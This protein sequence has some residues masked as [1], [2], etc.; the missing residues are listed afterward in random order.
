M[1]KPLFTL[2]LVAVLLLIAPTVSALSLDQAAI[3]ANYGGSW[4]AWKQ[5][6]TLYGSGQN[7]YGIDY[8]YT[9]LFPT[10]AAYQPS[11]ALAFQQFI[12]SQI[13]TFM[14]DVTGISVSPGPLSLDIDFLIF[15]HNTRI[16]SVVFYTSTYMGGAHPNN[17]A[18][19]LTFDQT[20]GQ[21]MQLEDFFLPA[22]DPL[23]VIEPIVV[24]DLQAQ[25]GNDS[26]TLQWIQ[27]GTGHDMDNYRRFALDEEAIYFFFDPYQVAPYVAGGRVVRVPIS[28]LQTVWH[29]GGSTAL[30]A[31]SLPTRLV[32][33]Y[34]GE[35]AQRF[36]TLRAQPAGS[37]ISTIYAPAAFRVLQG[38][39]CAGYESLAWY[40][41]QYDNGQRGW[42]SESQR[43][44]IWGRDRYWLAPLLVPD[45]YLGNVLAQDEGCGVGTCGFSL[46]FEIGN[47]G[48][49]DVDEPFRVLVTIP[50]QAGHQAYSEYL[51]VSDTVYAGSSISLFDFI[52]YST[53]TGQYPCLG[54]GCT[55]TMSIEAVPAGDLDISNNT[56]SVTVVGP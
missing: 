35:I 56:L 18:N 48:D 38:P 4:Y 33:G 22:S 15:R 29:S 50:E 2:M 43:L 36:S 20:T 9:V 6:C 31:G 53:D 39:V 19:T 21:L 34:R 32:P 42:A 5:E 37:Y 47:A 28:Q 45:L 17:W 40:E 27:S 41:I 10:A 26:A 3:C 14:L 51:W 46:D 30:C 13:D 7:S 16:F 11:I 52:T 23:T 25:L 54:E 1:H 44:S 55:F 24:A 49:V 8:S 12:E